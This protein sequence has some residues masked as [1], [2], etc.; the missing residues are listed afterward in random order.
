MQ[1]YDLISLPSLHGLSSLQTLSIRDC[2]GL[3]S[4]PSGQPSCTA[5]EELAIANYVNLVSIP[6]DLKRS[7]SILNPANLACLKKLTVGGFSTELQEFPDLSFIRSSLEELTLIAWGKPRERLLDQIQ[8]LT[9]FKYLRIRD[10][11]GLEAMLN[12]FENL[13]S[14]RTLW[15]SSANL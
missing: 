5:L 12:W 6:D 3:T 9:A 2:E 7:W 1:C 14:L 15:I 4:L 8:H 11:D 13:C 10:F